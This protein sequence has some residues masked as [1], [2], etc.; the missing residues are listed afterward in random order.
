MCKNKLT[1][2]AVLRRRKKNKKIYKARV[3]VLEEKE[4]ILSSYT[5][6]YCEYIRHASFAVEYCHY[7]EEKKIIKCGN[8]R[9]DLKLPF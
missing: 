6:E 5:C 3:C 7:K 1:L 8:S 9:I 2:L 4:K